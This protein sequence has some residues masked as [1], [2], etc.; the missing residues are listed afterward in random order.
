MLNNQSE[1]EI[2]T[3][4]LRR[5][6]LE[7]LRLVENDLIETI[8][9]HYDELESFHNDESGTVHFQQ[10]RVLENVLNKDFVKLAAVRS[11][12]EYQFNTTFINLTEKIFHNLFTDK[13]DKEDWGLI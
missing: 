12:I 1:N 3:A 4:F 10:I 13:N 6:K 5:Q 11:A 2:F 9:R 7:D 8:L